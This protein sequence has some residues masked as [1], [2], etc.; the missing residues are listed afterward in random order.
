LAGFGE[1][2]KKIDCIRKQLNEKSEDFKGSLAELIRELL[3]KHFVG[4]A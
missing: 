4:K 2:L 3:A 1:I